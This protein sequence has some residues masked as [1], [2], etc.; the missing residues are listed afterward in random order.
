[1][2]MFMWVSSLCRTKQDIVA[3]GRMQSPLLKQIA[4]EIRPSLK[5]QRRKMRTEKRHLY[6]Q[7]NADLHGGDTTQ[8]KSEAK[9]HR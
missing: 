1:M 2:S 3:S 5:R 8:L 6:I 9:I 7:Y 4:A